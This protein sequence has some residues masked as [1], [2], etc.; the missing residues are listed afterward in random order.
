MKLAMTLAIAAA[1]GGGVVM[2]VLGGPW[3]PGMRQA[4]RP[5]SGTRGLPGGSGGA[6]G[7]GW[8]DNFDSYANGSQLIGQGGWEGWPGYVNNNPTAFASTTHASSAPNGCRVALANPSANPPTDQ[9]DFVHTYNVTGGHWVYRIKTFMPSTAIATT[10]TYFILLN[11]YVGATST[12]DWSVQLHFDKLTGLVQADNVAGGVGTY[13]TAPLIMDQ[14]VQVVVDVDLNAGTS[15]VYTMTYGGAPIVTAA[16]WNSAGPL[17]GTLQAVDLYDDGV[18]EFYFDDAS[19]QLAGSACYPNCDSSTTVPCLNVLDFS[20]F[21]NKFASGD[22]YANCDGS[23]TV[24][25]LNVLDFGCFLNRF[26][27]GCSNC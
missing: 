12:F 10:S 9:S 18:D 25:I 11:T 20:C 6:D 22:T 27:A 19:L 1:G 4:A 5:A 21:L 14:W 16:D 23:T 3:R 26:S 15:G 8:S 7:P 24:P 2:P 17:P 13:T